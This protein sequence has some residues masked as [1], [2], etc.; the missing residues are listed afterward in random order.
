MR[1]QRKQVW[2][3]LLRRF[4]IKRNRGRSWKEMWGQS[5]LSGSVVLKHVYA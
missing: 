4:P 2:M 5:I 1:K 3:A